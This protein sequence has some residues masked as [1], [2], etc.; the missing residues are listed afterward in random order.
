MA[1]ISSLIFICFK[2][3]KLLNYYVFNTAAKSLMADSELQ[4]CWR[5]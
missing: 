5:I 4:A 2:N 3:I 1:L